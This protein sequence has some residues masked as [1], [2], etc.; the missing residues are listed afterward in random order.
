MGYYINKTR[1]KEELGAG[2]VLKYNAL[3]EDGAVPIARPTI[4]KEGL[5]CLI[6]NGMFAA[7]GYAY[8]EDEMR[9]FLEGEEGRAVQW[10]VYEHAKEMAA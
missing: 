9:V 4:W 10:F 1:K 5:V 3:K 6:N 7:A 8:N 2:F